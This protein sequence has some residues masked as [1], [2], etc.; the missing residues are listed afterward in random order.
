M[1][2]ARGFKGFTLIELLV[3]ISIIAILSVVGVTVFTGTQKNSRDA[4]R[5]ADIDSIAKVMEV[6]KGQCSYT[7]LPYDYCDLKASFF[8]G[9]TVPRDPSDNT[10]PYISTGGA[11]EGRSDNNY[12]FCAD[13]E[14][15]GRDAV[16]PTAS[17]YAGRP[18]QEDYCKSN[19][20]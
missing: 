20:Q 6:N 11:Y 12:R 10:T 17:P 4:K 18:N 16:D 5:R 1:K 14:A 8:S 15:D 3:V 7:V 13:L 2:S 19:T 9:G